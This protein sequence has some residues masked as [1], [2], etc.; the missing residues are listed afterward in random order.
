MVNASNKSPGLEPATEAMEPTSSSAD[1]GSGISSILRHRWGRIDI[2]IAA[3]VV[4]S[5]PAHRARVVI[6]QVNTEEDRA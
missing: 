2:R 1:P 5:V 3:G 6:D 4:I